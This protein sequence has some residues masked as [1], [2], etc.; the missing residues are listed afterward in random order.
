MK[1]R[2]SFSSP[3]P[4]PSIQPEE[5]AG[6]IRNVIE[7]IAK[8]YGYAIKPLE[9][10]KGLKQQAQSEVREEVEQLFLT[11]STSIRFL[12][13]TIA[14]M[15]LT[16]EATGNKSLTALLQKALNHPQ[17]KDMSAPIRIIPKRQLVEWV[18][19]PGKKAFLLHELFQK[20]LEDIPPSLLI[21][22]KGSVFAVFAN[23]RHVGAQD[24]TMSLMGHFVDLLEKMIGERV[25]LASPESVDALTNLIDLPARAVL[26]LMPRAISEE[27]K[28]LLA[29]GLRTQFDKHWEERRAL[30]K[31][32]LWTI[33]LPRARNAIEADTE[34]ALEIVLPG[35]VCPNDLLDPRYY[36][37]ALAQ[38]SLSE[39]SP[40]LEQIQE[41]DLHA[42]F[43]IRNAFI[44]SFA[45]ILPD[46][47]LMS[48][49]KKYQDG[50]ELSE[51]QKKRAFVNRSLLGMAPFKNLEF[52]GGEEVDEDDE[53]VDERALWWMYGEVRDAL[54]ES[55]TI[56]EAL[57]RLLPEMD[58]AF[59]VHGGAK[60]SEMI[61]RER[62]LS[63]AAVADR[64]FKRQGMEIVAMVMEAFF[65]NLA[66]SNR[67]YWEQAELLH[68]LKTAW[69]EESYELDQVEKASR[70]LLHSL[71][72]IIA[73]PARHVKKKPSVLEACSPL[74]RAWTSNDACLRLAVLEHVVKRDPRVQGFEER[75][76]IDAIELLP[77]PSTSVPSQVM[78]LP[79]I[80][81]NGCVLWAWWPD[82]ELASV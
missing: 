4:D 13:N 6:I 70:S 65:Y 75:V 15:E 11:H 47:Q 10:I 56:D 57:D 8:I 23:A 19:Q 9:E 45:G 27:Q 66:K 5:A 36:A 77:F 22:L 29:Q 37:W 38:N 31:K 3:E 43:E 78:G 52:Y 62:F 14:A 35:E 74:F 71:E 53:G 24:E 32:D 59:L 12:R 81:D 72:S 61:L 28:T 63:W 49:P 42:L 79:V 69:Q 17:L 21:G 2:D 50:R 55:N 51:E 44:G 20:G 60:E 48:I 30:R 58:V 39:N 41:Q 33:R 73:T 1:P 46:I 18:E 67:E 82:R 64:F 25:G 16:S 40:L 76:I 54:E 7:K 68:H 26:H 80:R 34:K